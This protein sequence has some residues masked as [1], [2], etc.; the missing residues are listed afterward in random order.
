MMLAKMYRSI[1]YKLYAFGKV[2][3][4]NNEPE[5]GAALLM[6]L[7]LLMNI[8]SLFN[9]LEAISVHVA[10]PS[11]GIVIVLALC[12]FA[13]FEYMLFIRKR[14]FL[15]IQK[16]FQNEDKTQSHRAVGYTILYVFGSF[17][18]FALSIYV[19]AFYKGTL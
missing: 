3:P 6:A 12:A 7:L 15:E 14:K 5:W 1:F 11:S 19:A 8:L 18:L 2:I 17:G 10:I 16:E 9:A 4:A 13:Y